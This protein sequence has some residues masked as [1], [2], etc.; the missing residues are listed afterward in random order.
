[1]GCTR[2]NYAQRVAD[3]LPDVGPATACDASALVGEIKQFQ[4]QT[5]LT[6]WLLL[7]PSLAVLG[8][9]LHV[10]P[11]STAEVI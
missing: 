7:P 11:V 2:K 9:Q 5:F 8:E 10:I 6:A 4:C 3:G 1:M